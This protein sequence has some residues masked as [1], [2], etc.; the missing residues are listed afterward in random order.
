MGPNESQSVQPAAVTHTT[1]ED[2]RR[3]WL[4]ASQQ[5]SVVPTQVEKSRGSIITVV[6]FEG[7]AVLELA[8]LTIRI[9]WKRNSSSAHT[10][11]W[12]CNMVKRSAGRSAC[13]NTESNWAGVSMR[14]IFK[15]RNWLPW[16]PIK[17]AAEHMVIGQDTA[18]WGALEG[19]CVQGSVAEGETGIFG[20]SVTTSRVASQGVAGSARKSAVPGILGSGLDSPWE[21]TST[22][23]WETRRSSSETHRIDIGQQAWG[24]NKMT[25]P[26]TT[27]QERSKGRPWRSVTAKGSQLSSRT[28]A[29][30]TWATVM[31][32]KV[33]KAIGTAIEPTQ[34]TNPWVLRSSSGTRKASAWIG[35]RSRFWD[36][37]STGVWSYADS[38]LCALALLANT[39]ARGRGS[40][41]VS[42]EL[43]SPA[44]SR[45]KPWKIANSVRYLST[46]SIT[47]YLSRR[48]LYT[49]QAMY[50]GIGS[51]K[52]C[53]RKFK[54][55][56]RCKWVR[57]NN[58][59]NDAV[60]QW[61]NPKCMRHSKRPVRGN[62]DFFNGGSVDLT[63][64]I[65]Q[66]G[67]IL[68]RTRNMVLWPKN[69]GSVDQPRTKCLQMK[70][71]RASTWDKF[72]VVKKLPD[73]CK[74]PQWMNRRS[75]LTNGTKWQLDI[76]AKG[77]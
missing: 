76:R 9:M 58:L 31:F 28:S 15:R 5:E 26:G 21:R 29:E 30:T 34:Y 60:K 19:Y 73:L 57:G 32:G 62:H 36:R 39:P 10:V 18:F 70:N 1:S 51:I 52:L 16:R 64:K 35:K 63:P 37:H 43:Q 50:T 46:D 20:H 71:R 65:N 55:S 40:G 24:H 33:L 13:L 72:M 44:G 22:S 75:K 23:I 45:G 12:C 2:C 49:G 41:M 42:M 48:I 7:W 69:L 61:S 59:T 47:K 53:T 38:I 14:G 25:V 67:E 68:V 56:S 74:D 4:Q 54:W 17:G 11:S 77:H 8:S 3:P 6:D 27:L 66:A